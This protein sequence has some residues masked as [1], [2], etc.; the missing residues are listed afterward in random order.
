MGVRARFLDEI[1]EGGWRKSKRVFSDAGGK[2][3]KEEGSSRSARAASEV[4]AMDAKDCRDWNAALMGYFW[5]NKSGFYAFEKLRNL[6]DCERRLLEQP[7]G[8]ESERITVSIGFFTGY[9]Q[10]FK[11]VP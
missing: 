6:A 5:D 3:V 11:S 4:S 7:A 8:D 10:D 2:T 1:S 9:S